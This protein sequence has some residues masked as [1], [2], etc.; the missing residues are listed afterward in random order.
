M[1]NFSSIR[2][3]GKN[4][5]WGALFWNQCC[6]VMHLTEKLAGTYQRLNGFLS[7]P[8]FIVFGGRQHNHIDLLGLRAPASTEKV[9][10][11]VQ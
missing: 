4:W 9:G 7:V 11:F 8:N 10:N 6:L 1:I 3:K 2:A 5:D